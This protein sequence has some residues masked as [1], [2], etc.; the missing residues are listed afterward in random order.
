MMG[1]YHIF[2]IHIFFHYVVTNTK[3]TYFLCNLYFL[4]ITN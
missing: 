3:N 2:N 1:A 4:L